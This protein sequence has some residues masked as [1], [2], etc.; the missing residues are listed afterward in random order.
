MKRRAALSGIAGGLTALTGCVQRTPIGGSSDEKSSKPLPDR[1]KTLN[2]TTALRYAA[3]Y[4]ETRL[5]NDLL[6]EARK[7]GLLDRDIETWCYGG[8][9]QS[10]EN[11]F[12]ILFECGGSIDG[13]DTGGGGGNVVAYLITEQTTRRIGVRERSGEESLSSTSSP[14]VDENTGAKTETTELPQSSLAVLNFTEKEHDSRVIITR[15]ADASDRV[16]FSG[17]YTLAGFTGVG[18]FRTVKS[19]GRYRVRISVENGSSE[20]YLWELPRDELLFELVAYIKPSGRLDI[21]EG[22]YSPVVN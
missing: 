13:R 20:T 7:Q 15:I 16:Q 21:H 17:K 5:H 4:E 2:R 18:I 3:S 14:T 12:Y 10:A 9:E 11:R 19:N 1:P 22:S 6:A 8:V